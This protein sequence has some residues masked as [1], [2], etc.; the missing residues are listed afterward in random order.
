MQTQDLVRALQEIK[1][2]VDAV[3]G[4]QKVDAVPSV[5]RAGKDSRIAKKLP[6]RLPE[7]LLQLRDQGYFKQPKTYNEAHS[8]LAS[9]YP[10]ESARVRVALIRLQK[11]RQLRKAPKVVNGRKQNAY[12]W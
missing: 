6:A 3:L 7:F 8:K 12:V 9:I 4:D 10:C 11:G 2:I 5:R 1:S